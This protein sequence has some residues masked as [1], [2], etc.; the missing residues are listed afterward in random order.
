MSHSVTIAP[1][2]SLVVISDAH[3]GEVPLAMRAKRIVSTR[4]CIAVGC[5]MFADGPSRFTLGPAREV[6][7]GMPPSFEG[8][9]EA[10]SRTV[11]VSTVERQAL[12]RAQ[13]PSR[14]VRVRIWTN[15]P[16]E[17]NEVV[18]GLG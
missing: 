10:P 16:T 4:S 6:D 2:N 9:L 15:H 17:P 5:R 7:P 1:P 12:R 13:V 11:V 3:G 18:I 8:S 14:E